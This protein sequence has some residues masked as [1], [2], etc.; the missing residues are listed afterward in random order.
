VETGLAFARKA[1]FTL[2]TDFLVASWRLV[3]SLRGATSALGS[4]DDAQFSEREFEEHLAGGGLSLGI[5]SYWYFVRK[6]QCRL[7]AADFAGAVRAL[8]RANEL[9]RGSAVFLENAEHQFYGAL[10]LAAHHD[11]EER[12]EDLDALVAHRAQLAIWAEACPE[13]FLH[14][15]ALVCA[16][17]ARIAGDM[18]TAVELYERAIRSARENGFVQNLALSLEFASRFYRARGI[19]LVADTYLREARAAYARWGAEGKV[20]QLDRLHPT[21]NESFPVGRSATFEVRTEQLDLYSIVRASHRISSEIARDALLRTLMQVVLELSGART[22]RVLLNRRDDLTMGAEATLDETGIGTRLLGGEGITSASAVPLSIVHYVRRTKTP[23]LLHDACVDAGSFA[24]DDYLVRMRPRSLLCLPILRQAEMVGLLYLENELASGA[25]TRDHLTAL[26]LIASQAAI[27]L[28]NALL[29]EREHAARTEAEA[30]RERAQLLDEATALLSSVVEYPAIL[31]ELV[32]FCVR[33]LA[34]WAVID[35]IEDGRLQGAASAHRD[36]KSEELLRAM[37][38]RFPGQQASM[39]LA[40]TVLESGTSLF[41]PVVDLEGIRVTA[42]NEAHAQ[43]I[44]RLGT[45]SVMVVPLLARGTQ[46]G[47]LSLAARTPGRYRTHDLELAEELARRAAPAIDSARLAQAEARSAGRL[48]RVALAVKDMT[49]TPLQNILANIELLQTRPETQA[50]CLER[51][52]R[53]VRR[54][55][56]L[57]G[58]LSVY[59]SAVRWRKSDEGFDPVAVIE[60]TTTDED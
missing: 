14:R 13:N 27:S 46:I 16:E 57:D 56:Q 37:E 59:G 30:A 51:M 4:F 43:M 18:E 32:R 2:A 54:L 36:P 35:L 39:P 12:R 19:E 25:F 28:E 47:A 21:L 20:R 49:N 45:G 22:A 29:L 15:H 23:V 34:D 53:A 60:G 5:A 55:R 58:A 38:M 1:G 40:L 24:A 48:A 9:S 44:L 3:Q 52:R 50:E 41:L 26:E 17:I 31:T 6:L 8:R 10:A 42:L 11:E 7:F 33:S